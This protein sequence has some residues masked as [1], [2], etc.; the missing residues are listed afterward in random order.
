M[1][2]NLLFDDKLPE[3]YSI[4]SE[5]DNEVVES[6]SFQDEQCHENSDIGQLNSLEVSEVSMPVKSLKREESS[7]LSAT[8]AF[9]L[10][11]KEEELDI[12]PYL[13]D[14]NSKQHILWDSGSQVTAWPPGPGD[15]V[16][17]KLTLR[18]VNGSKLKCYGYT[19]VKIRVN[20]KTYDIKAIKT[21]VQSPVLGF[22]FTKRHRLDTRWTE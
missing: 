12:R 7:F 6:E 20:R 1:K 4:I 2:L 16:D 22:N 13:F 21:D 15:K 5:A 14:S 8:E 3:I 9:R 11:H 10:Q 17:P 18:A 19:D